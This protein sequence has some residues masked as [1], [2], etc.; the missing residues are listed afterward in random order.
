MSENSPDGRFIQYLCELVRKEDRRQLA[1]LRR[2]LGKPPGTVWEMYPVLGRFL[3]DYRKQD[4]ARFLVA[5][6]FALHPNHRKGRS[7]GQV[8]RECGEH[9]SAE[10]RF[11]ALLASHRDELPDRLRRV[12]AMAKSRAEPVPVDYEALLRDLRNWNHPDHCV[13]ERWARDYWRRAPAA[14]AGAAAT[15]ASESD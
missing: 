11:Q 15:E 14:D 2:G 10:K 8:C 7:L 5:S 12:I 9:E 3:G 1:A 13:Q 6:L 4:E